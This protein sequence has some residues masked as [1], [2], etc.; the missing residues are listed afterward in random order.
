MTEAHHAPNIKVVAENDPPPSPK[1]KRGPMFLGL[2]IAV[3]ALGGGYH[4]Y[5][6]LYA[7]KHAVTDNAYVGADVAPINPLIAAAVMEAPVGD[8]QTVKAGDVLVRLD[9]T[10]ARLQYDIAEAQYQSALR[11]VRGYYANDKALAAQ[12]GARQADEV[13]AAAQT[14]AAEADASKARVDLERRRSLAGRGSVS[15][16]ELTAVDAAFKNALANLEVARASRELAAAG[17]EAAVAGREV[18]SA[19]IADVTPDSHPEVLAA[20]GIRDQAKVNLDR[21]VIRAPVDGVVSRRQVQ[22]GQRVQPGMTLMVVVPLNAVYVD[23]NFKEVQL[24]K[25][26]EGQTVTLTSDLRGS[27]I[28]YKGRVVGLSGGTGA[29]FSVVPAQ[30]AT[31]NWIKVVQRLPVRIA[32]DPVQLRE[33]PLQVG[34]SMT[35]DIH[36]AD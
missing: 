26:R 33:H 25:V 8:T 6:V 4:A 29:A 17:R 13:R 28:V 24:S 31:G 21:A 11:R 27:D 15:G 3:A 19:Q 16:D 10:D 36:T 35:A 23:A 30:N 22:V 20:R 1:G 9:D 12:I 7:S 34:L 14:T 2:F 32:L 5:D 18:N